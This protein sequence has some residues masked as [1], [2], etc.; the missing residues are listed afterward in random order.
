MRSW[1]K[2]ALSYLLIFSYTVD[3]GNC[4]KKV[5]EREIRGKTRFKLCMDLEDCHTEWS[6]SDQEAETSYDIPY[7]QNLRRCVTNK[8]I[9]KA[10]TDSENEL[11]VVDEDRRR[12]S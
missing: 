6:K 8:L 11:I 9:Y 1:E 12:D 7:M 2:I 10:E 4:R 3:I 5:F